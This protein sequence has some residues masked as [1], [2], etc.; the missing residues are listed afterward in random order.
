MYTKPQSTLL[1]VAL[2]LI[3]GDKT[4]TPIVDAPLPDEASASYVAVE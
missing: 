2:S 4:A 1:G 3:Q